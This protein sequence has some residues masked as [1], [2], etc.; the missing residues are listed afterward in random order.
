MSTVKKHHSITSPF[1]EGAK[2]S[3]F[4][5]HDQFGNPDAPNDLPTEVWFGRH[6]YI[7]KAIWSNGRGNPEY[8]SSLHFDDRT[9]KLCG[10]YWQIRTA[11]GRLVDGRENKE[12]PYAMSINPETG[13]PEALTFETF[14]EDGQDIEVLFDEN[15]DATDDN[16][17]PIDAKE[18]FRLGWLENIPQEA[19]IDSSK[20]PY[21][22]LA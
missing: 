3:I 22:D 11:D 20:N 21:F 13:L 8:P 4:R 16:L 14:G 19:L 1:T 9:G 5:C 10:A 7:S 17:N 18:L 2:P 6:G 12:I 15:G